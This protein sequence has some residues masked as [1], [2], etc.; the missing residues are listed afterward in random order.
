M[1]AEAV[2]IF[3]LLQDVNILRPLVFLARDLGLEP[4]LLVSSAF[5]DRDTTGLWRNELDAIALSAPATKSAFA[6]AAEAADALRAG[7]IV[8]AGSESNLDAH[9]FSHDALRVAPASYVTATLQHGFECVGFLHSR[10][11]DTAYG[12]EVTFAADVV[13]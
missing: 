10:A 8:F 2:F 4:R 3:N 7:G 13:C 11:H 6:N 5:A 1:T 12:R 9:N